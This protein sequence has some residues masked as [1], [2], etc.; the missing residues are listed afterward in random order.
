MMRQLMI[1]AVMVAAIAAFVPGAAGDPSGIAAE[2]LVVLLTDYG[3]S[4]FYV[5][6]LEGS[7]YSANPEARISTITHEV[8]AFNV[9]EGSYILAQAAREYPSGSVFA[10][11]VD[12]GLGTGERS[13]VLETKDGKLFVGPDN[14]LFTGVMDELGIAGIWEITDQNL[15]RE[16]DASFMFNG[17]DIYGPVAGHLSFGTDPSEVGPEIFDPVRIEVEKATLQ[18]ET[19]IGT[20]VHVDN[21]GHLTTNVPS[22]LVERARLVSGDHVEIS[23]GNAT[24]EALFATTYND[25]PPGEWVAM[26]GLSG[27]LVIARNMY[28]AAETLGVFAGA[29]VRVCEI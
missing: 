23:A 1:L 15:T 12:P 6:A 27:Q 9:A 29:E 8:A 3:T 18:N 21:W 14:G 28:S 11:E 19:L 2:N 26:I 22:S 17:R 4:D 24:K 13:I 5:G 7:I 20:V 25:V 10:A 16:G